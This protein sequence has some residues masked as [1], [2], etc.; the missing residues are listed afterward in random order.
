MRAGMGAGARAGSWDGAARRDWLARRAGGVVR[1][2]TPENI[3]SCSEKSC[4]VPVAHAAERVRCN[5]ALGRA[6]NGGTRAGAC[7]S[8]MHATR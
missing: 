4:R 8:G 6:L 1:W 3:G 7:D 2:T 5:L